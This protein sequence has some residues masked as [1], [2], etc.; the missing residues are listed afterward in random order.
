MSSTPIVFFGTDDFSLATLTALLRSEHQ[1]AAVVTKPDTKRGRG[2]KLLPPRVKSIAE[3]YD[4]PVLQPRTLSEITN[5]I[6]ELQP[7]VGVLVSF[8]KIIPASIIDLF[9]FG[10]INIHPSKLPRYRGPSPIESAILHG[11]SETGVSIMQLSAEMDAGPIYRF[12]P[13]P[14]SGNESQP[15]LYGALAEVGATALIEVLP[16][17]LDGSL[18]PTPQNDSE[19]TYCSLI[20]KTDGIIDWNKPAEQ[21]EREIRAYATWPQSRTELGGVPVIITAATLSSYKWKPTPGHVMPMKDKLFIGTGQ[22]WLE[23]LSLK[24]VGKKEMPAG[25]FLTGYKARLDTA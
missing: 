16:Q 9:A 22:G 13:Y 10:I 21:I 18:I 1:V 14:L 5:T 6:K 8:G 17:I 23:I 4:I 3:E 20:Q 25:A 19:A 24:P 7:A 12:T 2:H 11:D 15:A